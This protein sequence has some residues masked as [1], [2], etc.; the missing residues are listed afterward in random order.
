MRN[1]L[2]IVSGITTAALATALSVS[3]T[4]AVLEHAAAAPGAQRH[5]VHVADNGH[6]LRPGRTPLLMP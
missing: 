6:A 4:V 2:L 1:L 3:S 5:Q